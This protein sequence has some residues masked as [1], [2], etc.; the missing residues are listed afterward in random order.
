MVREVGTGAPQMQWPGGQSPRV[1]LR[2]ERQHHR[3]H[4]RDQG[5]ERNTHQNINE[6]FDLIFK[7]IKTAD[8]WTLQRHI[9]YNRDRLIDGDGR[10]I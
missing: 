3:V 6:M 9:F 1:L 7:H 2:E 8:Q 4:H 10:T 5:E